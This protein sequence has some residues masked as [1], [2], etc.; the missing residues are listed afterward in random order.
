MQ[1]PSSSPGKQ[2]NPTSAALKMNQAETVPLTTIFKN[3]PVV[4][5]QRVR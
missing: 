3:E 2:R 5:V 1:M 4:V